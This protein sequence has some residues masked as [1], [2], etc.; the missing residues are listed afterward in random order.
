VQP[1]APPCLAAVQAIC[2][3]AALLGAPSSADAAARLQ[4]FSPLELT[5]DSKAAM[6]K[7]LQRRI[8]I[9]REHRRGGGGSGR[10][11]SSRHD[12][13]GRAMEGR[14]GCGVRLETAAAGERELSSRTHH[15][16]HARSQQT[17][18]C[19][20]LAAAVQLLLVAAPCS[21]LLFLFCNAVRP[22]AFPLR[23]SVAARLPSSLEMTTETKGL[24][25]A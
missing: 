21:L 9:R 18:T 16:V 23:P 10:F 22:P 8:G 2:A 4:K 13:S 12:G 17:D 11:R 20:C 1:P 3:A 6:M 19:T 14:G 7:A 25:G 15:A 5:V 24:N